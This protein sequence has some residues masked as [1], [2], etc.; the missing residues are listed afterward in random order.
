M[1]GVRATV[2]T[3]VNIQMSRYSIDFFS[4]FD[5]VVGYPADY[6]AHGTSSAPRPS[7]ISNI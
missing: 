4:R 1:G 7:A 3:P 6:R 5:D 2:F